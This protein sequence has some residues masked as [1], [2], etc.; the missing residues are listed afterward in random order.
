MKT[1]VKL[2][3]VLT[4]GMV[5]LGASSSAQTQVNQYKFNQLFNQAFSNILAVDY[6]RALPILNRLHQS[7]ESHAQVSYLLAMCYLET[8]QELTKAVQLLESSLERYDA[9][10][11]FGRVEDR[12]APFKAWGL[13]AE[14]YM[15]T[16]RYREAVVTYRTYI[17]TIPWVSIEQKQ[18]IIARIDEAQYQEKYGTATIA[19][20]TNLLNEKP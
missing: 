11:Q 7:D 3:A 8:E 5:G 9:Y 4:V 17:S 19:L 10:H 20:V 6:E 12:T 2:F 1:I 15:K 13:L 14:A 18:Q 16:G